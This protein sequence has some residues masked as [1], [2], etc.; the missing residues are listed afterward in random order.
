M[1]G[2]VVAGVR[3]N[4]AVFYNPGAL[5]FIDSNTLSVRL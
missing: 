4:S 5:G 3:D 2:A 1:G